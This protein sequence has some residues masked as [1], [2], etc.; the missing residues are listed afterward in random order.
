MP[1]YKY[2]C[3]ICFNEETE[4]RSVKDRDKP[5]T[6]STCGAPMIRLISK[7]ALKIVDKT[8]WIKTYSNYS[9]K[10]SYSLDKDKTDPE[11][12]AKVENDGFHSF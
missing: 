1:M 2:Y 9:E 11:I 8:G 3:E 10:P 12:K 4:F 6:C 7:P 5:K